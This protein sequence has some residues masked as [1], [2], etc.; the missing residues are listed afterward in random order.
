MIPAKA[1][2]EMLIRDFVSGLDRLQ[3]SATWVSQNDSP[4]GKRAHLE[5]CRRGD[6][7]GRKVGNRVLVK[8]EEMDAYIE[9]HSRVTYSP[10]PTDDEERDARTRAM[11][12][13]AKP[14]TRRR[15]SRQVST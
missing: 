4:I 11:L 13:V 2:V 10:A 8:C 1:S 5:A 7:R 3:S 12:G 9:R 15:A 6:L 14:A